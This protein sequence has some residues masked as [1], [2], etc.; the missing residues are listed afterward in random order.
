MHV[1]TFSSAQVQQGPAEHAWTSSRRLRRRHL[2]LCNVALLTSG[3]SD[4]VKLDDAENLQEANQ[5]R[6]ACKIQSPTLMAAHEMKA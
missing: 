5:P 4:E 3:T 2:G 6:L 1:D